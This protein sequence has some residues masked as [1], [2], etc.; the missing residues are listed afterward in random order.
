MTAATKK[1]EHDWG[2]FIKFYSEQYVGR[3]T[4]LGVFERSRNI[5]NDYWIESGLPLTGLDIDTHNE[6]VA[7]QI[8]LDSFTHQVNHPVLLAFHFSHSGEEDGI[9]ITSL[10]GT[11]TILRFEPESR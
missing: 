9:D 7:I 2:R 5:A 11:T 6:K 1:A 10:D 8:E 4:R 3:P